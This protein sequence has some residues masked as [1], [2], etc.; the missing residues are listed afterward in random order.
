MPY[1]DSLDALAA[2]CDAVFVHTSTASHYEVVNHLLNAG[3][4]VCVDK[5]L[6]DKLSE[7]ETLVEL[8]AR[9]RLTLM[10]GFNRRFA[11]LY[12]ELKGRL[13]EAASLRMDK[14]RSDSVGNDLRFTLLDDYLH[15]VDTALWLA[16]GQARLRGGALKITPQ[17]E[18]LYAEH[19]FSSPRLQVTTSMHRR[20]GSQREWV[21]AVT[22]GGLYAVSE[23]REWQEECGHGVVQRPVAG[24]QT[25]LEQRGFVG[26]ARH[27]SNACKI[28]QFLKLQ[29]NRR[30]WLSG[31]LRNCGATPLA[32]NPL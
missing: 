4:H 6:A 9:R 8:A 7:A 24:W 30:C 18:M 27:L 5:P 11:P 10:V 19:Q 3:V 16:D 32:N 1:A 21:Q 28:R 13:G 2:Q 29:A 26:C 17:G 23:M 15:V 25:T 14:H 12:R 22:D 20:A 31:S